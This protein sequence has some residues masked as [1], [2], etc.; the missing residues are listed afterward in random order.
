MEMNHFKDPYQKQVLANARAF[1]A[2][3]ANK[4]IAV[5]GG[6]EDG[7]TSTHQVVIR[8][9]EHGDGKEIAN[10]LEQNNII[11]NYQALPD[12]ET[13]YHPSGIRM[14]VSE[15][16][17]FGMKENDLDE[18]SRMLADVVI[19]N[20][21]IGDDV[22]QYRRGFQNMEYCLSVEDTLDIAPSIFESLFPQSVY[23]ENYV[24]ALTSLQ[25]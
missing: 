14:G 23:F 7:F 21:S 3:L 25:S 10:R 18:L 24:R 20:R 2:A 1:A 4:G 13:F 17:R 16:T 11:T 15:M 19:H 9:S 12:D 8:V 22:A 5:E 6:E